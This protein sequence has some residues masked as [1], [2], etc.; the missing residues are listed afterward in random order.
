MTLESK[1]RKLTE[2]LL[3][4]KSQTAASMWSEELKVFENELGKWETAFEREVSADLEG[5][6]PWES[7]EHESS[8]C[9]I[10]L[11]R[12]VNKGKRKKSEMLP[13]KLSKTQQEDQCR[14]K[15]TKRI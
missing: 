4:S 9:K 14:K 3:F 2:R 5:A 11:S 10:S 1:V 13:T 7:E 8:I 6:T 15:K 12:K